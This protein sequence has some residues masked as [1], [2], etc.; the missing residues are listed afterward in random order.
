MKYY[1]R[2]M[3]KI[4]L[5]IIKYTTHAHINA[6]LPQDASAMDI[7]IPPITMGNLWMHD[8]IVDDNAGIGRHT[9]L[10]ILVHYKRSASI[11]VRCHYLSKILW[12]K[13]P[14][15]TIAAHAAAVDIKRRDNDAPWIMT[16][17]SMENSYCSGCGRTLNIITILV[18][19]RDAEIKVI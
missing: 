3:S 7:R 15:N 12:T 4:I 1:W 13:F 18:N 11:S 9:I 8:T 16:D 10:K 14:Q 5:T 19:T 2:T 6:A 17:I